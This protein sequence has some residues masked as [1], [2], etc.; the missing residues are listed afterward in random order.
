MIRKTVPI[1]PNELESLIEACNSIPLSLLTDKTPGIFQVPNKAFDYIVREVEN[2]WT[3]IQFEAAITYY[4]QNPEALSIEAYSLALDKAVLYA[5]IEGYE[6]W[7]KYQLKDALPDT[8]FVS[9]R[10]LEKAF[11]LGPKHELVRLGFN[12]DSSIKITSTRVLTIL[13]K[14]RIP[15]ERLGACEVCGDLYWVRRLGTKYCWKQKC[16]QRFSKRSQRLEAD[17][18]NLRELGANYDQKKWPS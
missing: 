1:Y 16:Q 8:S 13:E 2:N 5:I 17:R 14:H 9:L 11:G 7:S 4:I 6:N 15:I 10:I 18:E 12:A 3:S